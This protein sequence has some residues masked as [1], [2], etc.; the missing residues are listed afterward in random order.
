MKVKVIM[1]VGI[2]VVNVGMNSFPFVRMISISRKCNDSS[3]SDI[4]FPSSIVKLILGCNSFKASFDIFESK[5]SG[6]T[7]CEGR[8]HLK[9]SK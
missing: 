8:R 7:F 5:F 1:W 6:K 9:K 3:C 4:D 2:F